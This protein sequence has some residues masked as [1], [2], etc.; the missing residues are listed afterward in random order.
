MTVATSLLASMQ[1]FKGSAVEIVALFALLV[2]VPLAALLWTRR[3]RGGASDE[4]GPG[5][6]PQA[7]RNIGSGGR[8]GHDRGDEWGDGGTSGL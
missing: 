8:P 1:P 4:D 3:N 7:H 6:D 5:A 2:A